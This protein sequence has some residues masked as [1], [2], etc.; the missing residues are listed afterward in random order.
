[1]PPKRRRMSGVGGG[2]NKKPKGTVARREDDAV[3]SKEAIA[4]AATNPASFRAGIL[5]K[6]AIKDERGVGFTHTWTPQELRDCTR[7]PT[8]DGEAFKLL[9]TA[10]HKMGIVR[11]DDIEEEFAKNFTD[12][13]WDQGQRAMFLPHYGDNEKQFAG[14]SRAEVAIQCVC[15]MCAGG[16]CV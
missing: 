3:F 11:L 12:R 9:P 15:V 4:E 6:Y 14:L 1:M 16:V 5:D 10:L 8:P 2:K 7:M 13:G